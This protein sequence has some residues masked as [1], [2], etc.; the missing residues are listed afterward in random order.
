MVVA[1]VGQLIRGLHLVQ[2]GRHRGRVGRRD[3]GKQHLVIGR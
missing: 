3:I 1:A 2:F